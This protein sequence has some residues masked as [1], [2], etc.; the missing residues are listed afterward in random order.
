M[1]HDSFRWHVGQGIVHRI[2][3]THLSKVSPGI[4]QRDNEPTF[5][6]RKSVLGEVWNSSS[7]APPEICSCTPAVAWF[8]G[9][10]LTFGYRVNNVR[11]ARSRYHTSTYRTRFFVLFFLRVLLECVCIYVKV[12]SRLVRWCWRGVSLGGSYFKWLML[13]LVLSGW[14]VVVAC[15]YCRESYLITIRQQYKCCCCKQ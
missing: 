11:C 10:L 6:F 15:G 9:I 7:E 14:C 4:V 13:L 1:L 8:V 5:Y 3:P 12:R 2:K